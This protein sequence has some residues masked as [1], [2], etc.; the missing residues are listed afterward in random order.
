MQ[1]YIKLYKFD[2]KLI[3]SVFALS[4]L[5]PPNMG[6]DIF[7]INFDDLPLLVIFLV[8]ITKKLI[9]F[10]LE[11][12]DRIFFIFVLSFFIYVNIFVEEINYLNKTNLRFVFYFLLCYLCVDLLFKNNQSIMQDMIL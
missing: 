10:K 4:L 1:K 9:N 11:K 3:G 7:G 8:L 6:F 12:Q 2:S 5:I